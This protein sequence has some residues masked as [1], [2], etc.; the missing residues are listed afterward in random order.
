MAC[1]RALG[2]PLAECAIVFL[3]PGV[4]HRFEWDESA[5]R[6]GR[7]QISQAMESLISGAWQAE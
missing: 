2:Q 1:E 6:R 7:Q 3:A 5:R 4:E